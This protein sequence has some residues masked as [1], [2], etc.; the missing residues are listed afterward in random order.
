M[1]TDQT[2]NEQL[3]GGPVTDNEL[4]EI[5]NSL[6]LRKASGN[7]KLQNEHLRYGGPKVIKCVTIMF[8]I[9]IKSSY[10]PLEWKKGLIVPIFKGGN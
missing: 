6:K 1:S 10:I 2:E 8:N 5:I 7:D 4:Y 3:P 9:I